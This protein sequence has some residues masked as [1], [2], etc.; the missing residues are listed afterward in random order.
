MHSQSRTVDHATSENSITALGE[1]IERHGR[2]N[3]LLSDRDVQFY[4]SGKKGEPGTPNIFQ[5]FL[6]ANKIKQILARVNH[7][8]TC[9][10]VERF[11]GE[12]KNRLRWND[13]DNVDDIIKWHNE[14]KPH[15]SPRED[16]LETPCCLHE[17]V[18]LEEKGK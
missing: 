9:G 4:A 11:F 18:A 15:G 10:K 5:Q 7:P 8:Q 17:E 2:P 14:V 12:V 13:F 16:V 6:K 1:A 3:V